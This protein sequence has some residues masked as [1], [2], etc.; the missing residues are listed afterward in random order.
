MGSICTEITITYMMSM[1]RMATNVSVLILLCLKHLPDNK[2]HRLL[3]NLRLT[4]SLLKILYAT[5]PVV[6][7]IFIS[8][9]A[10]FELLAMHQ[11]ATL[12]HLGMAR[13]ASMSEMSHTLM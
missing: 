6:C 3:L 12:D 10:I 11:A 8:L 2:V 1:W 7:H 13:Q 5:T 4:V 9:L